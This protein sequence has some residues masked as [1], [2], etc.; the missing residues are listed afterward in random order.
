MGTLGKKGFN[1]LSN[2]VKTHQVKELHINNGSDQNAVFLEFL[3][4]IKDSH[5]N[6]MRFSYYGIEMIEAAVLNPQLTHLELAIYKKTDL[7]EAAE[8]VVANFY[9]I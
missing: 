8:A 3:K 9:S 1:K 4:S 5:I 6:H 7:F 2:I